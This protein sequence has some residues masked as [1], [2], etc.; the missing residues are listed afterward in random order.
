MAVPWR[1]PPVTENPR[2][3][4]IFWGAGHNM[5]RA[6]QPGWTRDSSVVPFSTN[7]GGAVA[8]RNPTSDH[9]CR[10]CKAGHASP[11][12]ITLPIKTRR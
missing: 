12:Q 6:G 3:T 5:G 7:G 9:Y 2:R 4:I 11:R 1:W 10:C 8:A